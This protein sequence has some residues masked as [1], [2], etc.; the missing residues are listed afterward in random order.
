MDLDLLYVSRH[1]VI[2]A[3]MGCVWVLVVPG[4]NELA[5]ESF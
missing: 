5:K 2:R 1:S 3:T 4:L